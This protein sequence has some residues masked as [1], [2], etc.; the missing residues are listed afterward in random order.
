M[1]RTNNPQVSTDRVTVMIVSHT[2]THLLS[3]QLFY[4]Y[5]I[6]QQLKMLYSEIMHP[7]LLEDHPPPSGVGDTGAGHSATPTTRD[8]GKTAS[9]GAGRKEKGGSGG[10]DKKGKTVK[11]ETQKESVHEVT[12]KKILHGFGHIHVSTC[13]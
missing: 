10:K 1:F 7:E 8:K 3:A 9:G 5:N 2:H 12:G 11:E 13:L 6:V 4:H